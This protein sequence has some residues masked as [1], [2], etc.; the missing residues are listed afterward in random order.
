[1]F[2][3]DKSENK[4][5][6]AGCYSG[7]ATSSPADPAL[8]KTVRAS[9]PHLRPLK[10]L[11]CSLHEHTQPFA[12]LLCRSFSVP[13]ILD[14][15]PAIPVPGAL[16]ARCQGVSGSRLSHG[17]ERY[18]AVA[19]GSCGTHRFGPCSHLR[20]RCV[21][22]AL[23][24]PKLSLQPFQVEHLALLQRVGSVRCP[25]LASPNGNSFLD[26]GSRPGLNLIRFKIEGFKNWND[27]IIS[28]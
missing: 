8:D 21:G 5:V 7:K 25:P 9:A 27:S 2:R 24:P 22:T 3:T 17:T 12:P 23:G 14:T 28:S 19:A 4:P 13:S 20:F 18:R 15:D 26:L 16:E 1:M 11:A 6:P 10:F